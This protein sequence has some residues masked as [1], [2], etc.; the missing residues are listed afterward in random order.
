VG[1]LCVIQPLALLPML[2]TWLLVLGISGWVGLATILA[3]I[4]LVPAML[5]LQA[6]TL[7]FGFSIVLAIFLLLTHRRNIHNMLQ[8]S[9][10]RF[11]KAMIRS[12][13]R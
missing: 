4:S 6:S 2:G 10:H 12:W 3:G 1:V 8:G 11:E 7:Q 13:F 9:E 5:W